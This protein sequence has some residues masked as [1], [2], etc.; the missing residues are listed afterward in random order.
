[1]TLLRDW[2]DGSRIDQVLLVRDVERREKRDG[3]PFMRVTLADRSGTVPA[4]LWNAADVASGAPFRVTGLL[5]DHPRYGRQV[6]IQDLRAPDPDEIEWDALVDAPARPVSELQAGLDELIASVRDERLRGLLELLLG[7]ASPSGL[8]YREMP[9]AKYNHAYHHGLLEHSLQI[10][11]LVS[12][13]ASVFAGID[14]DLAVAG[15]LLHD[16]GKLEAYVAEDGCIHLTDAGKLEGEIPLG[17]YRVR[18]A[19]EELGFPSERARALLHIILSHHG[20]LQ[21]GS[22]VVPSTREASLVRA[23]DSL[24]GQMGAFDRL[25][26]ATE[27]EERW[28]RYDRVLETSAFFG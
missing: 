5:A 1:M 25:E 26:K 11:Q 7:A 16:F 27:P 24:S 2:N 22:P 3:S 28:S 20:C 15:A 17:Y 8:R 14:R 23:M 9:A 12:N 10:A 19:V 18:R 6:T 4:V 13:G 21:Y